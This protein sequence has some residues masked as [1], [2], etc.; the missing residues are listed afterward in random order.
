MEKVVSR[1]MALFNTS[2]EVGARLLVIFNIIER[3]LSLEHVIHLDYILV[4]SGDFPDAPFSIHANV[5]YRKGELLVKREVI[6]KA[7][8][9]LVVKGL[10]AK[11]YSQDG[12]L[13][14]R[15]EVTGSFL[16]YFHS[17]YFRELVGVAKWMKSKLPIEDAKGL[18]SY[19]KKNISFN[20]GQFDL[21]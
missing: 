6:S 2:F 16:S 11:E 15:N 4:H 18:D 8:D 7:L 12:I 13:F 19:F 9:L 1:T 5:P 17:E 20:D 10:I 14:R 21:G 3:G